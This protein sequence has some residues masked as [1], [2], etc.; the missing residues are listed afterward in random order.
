MEIFESKKLK[1]VKSHI[2]NLISIANRDGNFSIAEK[3]LI[4]AIGR[5][6]GLSNEKLKSIVKS[7]EPIKF[8]VP[9]NDSSRF[10]QVVELVEM[11]LADGVASEN[12]IATCIE[13]AEKLGFRKAIVGVL[14]RKLVLGMSEGKSA[15][16]LKMECAN[17]LK[18]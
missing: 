6:Q 11:L 2:N 9:D 15:M 3:R 10:D 4:F 13:L 5:R 14:V 7:N 16:E 18:F 8:K 1:G 17:F 12:E